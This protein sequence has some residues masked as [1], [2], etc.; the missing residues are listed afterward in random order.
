MA[1]HND[2]LH[3]DEQVSRRLI[4]DQFPEWRLEHVVRIMT[5]GTVNAIFRIGA[6][7]TARFPLRSADPTDMRAGHAVPPA[8]LH[9]QVSERKF[10]TGRNL[11]QIQRTISKSCC[12]RL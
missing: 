11:G 2:E 4:N 7:L 10:R 8:F 12:T 9:E 1:I 5:A 6:D 3:I